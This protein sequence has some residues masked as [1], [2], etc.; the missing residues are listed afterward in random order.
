M[1]EFLKS[2]RKYL[3]VS[4]VSTAGF[5]TLFTY[6]SRNWMLVMTVSGQECFPYRHWVIKKT[7]DLH[8]GEFIAF[9]G[10]GIPNT[11]ERVLWGK[12]VLAMGGDRVVVEKT[13]GTGIIAIDGVDRS[14]PIQGLVHV[15]DR[16]GHQVRSLTV[17]GQDTFSRPLP[18]IHSMVI[19]E[20]KYFVVGETERS[21]DSRYWG[22]VDA[23]WVVGRAYPVI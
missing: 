22:L 9:R 1:V 21:Y 13:S 14:F 12:R 19:P 15:Y 2:R 16:S 11:P 17:Y 6:L 18:M 4:L 5:L 7:R 8:V 3:L 23:S 20:G 10:Y